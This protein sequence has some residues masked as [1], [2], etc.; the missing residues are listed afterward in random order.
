[1]S[2]T[3]KGTTLMISFGSFTYTGYVPEG[4]TLSFPNLNVEVLRD[5]DGAT[6]T[7]ILMDP[8]QKIS[9][10]FIILG[11]SGSITP[12]SEGG[13]VGLIPPQGTLTTY[14]VEA[15]D[16]KFAAGATRLTLELIKE[17]SMTYS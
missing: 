7:K 8:A 9:G 12:P 5:K 15:A 13:S 10:T 14:Y 11:A 6:Q 1:M 16:S 2:A 17:T 4:M 3:Q